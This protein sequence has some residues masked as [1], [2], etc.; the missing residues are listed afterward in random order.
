VGT[1]ATLVA[2][3]WY[4]LVTT[5]SPAAAGL[6]GFATVLCEVAS[7]LFAGALVDRLGHR[8]AS[9]AADLGS[10]AAV[11]AIPALHATV[12]LAYWQLVALVSLRALFD[13]PGTAA[14]ASLVP[15]TA[16]AAGMRIER[17]NSLVEAIPGAAALAGAPLAG[18]LIVL[19][20]P[21]TVLWIDAASFAASALVLAAGVPASLAPRVR[22][23]GAG[24]LR[25]V[26]EGLR[27]LARDSVILS[28]AA[29]I[30]VTNF[31]EAP[32]R[33]VLVPVYAREGH[34]GAA[35]LGLLLAGQAA[36]AL[37]GTLLYGAASSRL[38]RRS[39]YVLCFMA[40]GLGFWGL[41]VAPGVPAA[42]AL[43]F[44]AGAVGGP[45]N[46]IVMTVIQERCPTELRG[47]VIGAAR[48][49]AFAAFPFGALAGG[50]A[51]QAFGV[52][53]VLVGLGAAFLATTASMWL[54]PSLRS[55]EPAAARSRG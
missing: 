31:L 26:R 36:G 17:A 39:T 37:A 33:S 15:D 13:A 40:S 25:E 14:W 52:R 23:A 55:L 9:V 20:G 7:G 5:G 48:A 47:R 12:G 1:A 34:G 53:A 54:N 4:V 18:L 38:P 29:T 24:Y 32:L 45:I 35:G 41:A 51:V 8:G 27:A 44:L 3:P 22:L 49:L 16:A 21:V 6:V 2:V 19:V 11:A 28:I 46:P 30:A 50:V 10:A 43:L 42:V